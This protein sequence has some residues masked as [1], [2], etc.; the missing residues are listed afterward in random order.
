MARTVT[1]SSLESQVRQRSDTESLT[2]RFPQAEV[3]EYINQSWAELYNKIVQTG[4]EYYLSSSSFTTTAGTTDYAVPSDFY[5]DKGC[6]TTIN[7]Q[8]FVLDRWLWEERGHYDLMTRWSPGMPWSYL[9]V[10]SNVSL[11]PAPAAVYTVVLWYYPAPTRMTASGHTIDCLAGFEE[12]IVCDAAAKILV[13]DD[14]DPSAV[15]TQ[16]A[17]AEQVIDM[18][19]SNRSRSQPNRVLDIWRKG[20]PPLRAV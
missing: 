6:D 4:Q 11:R 1:L 2:D 15:L 16:K 3:W 5:L 20:T 17:A 14:R 7:G 10:G 9:V 13:K 19:I 18:M 8:V 12:Y